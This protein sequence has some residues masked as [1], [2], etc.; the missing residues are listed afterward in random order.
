MA[1]GLRRSNATT[2]STSPGG[3][4]SSRLGTETN[5][6]RFKKLPL[7]PPVQTTNLPQQSSTAAARSQSLEVLQR[8]K[9]LLAA[10]AVSN[11]GGSGKNDI[12]APSSPMTID[13]TTNSSSENVN[14]Q[15]NVPNTIDG[16]RPA[17]PV[18]PLLSIPTKPQPPAPPPP[19]PKLAIS[20]N[21]QK[22][23]PPPPQ[24]PLLQISKPPPSINTSSQQQPQ[25]PPFLQIQVN[26]KSN[27]HHHQ[28]QQSQAKPQQ[29]PFLPPLL[30]ID[31]TSSNSQ[32]PITNISINTN[33]TGGAPGAIDTN[34]GEH[35]N[36]DNNLTPE[37]AKFLTNGSQYTTRNTYTNN[38]S[39]YCGGLSIATQSRDNK[40]SGGNELLPELSSNFSQLKLDIPGISGNHHHHR[41]QD[42]IASQNSKD[43]DDG[44][45]R[46]HHDPNVEIVRDDDA[47]IGGG[48]GGGRSSSRQATAAAA[49]ITG[50][51]SGRGCG[52]EEAVG[53]DGGTT[54]TTV[55]AD[56]YNLIPENI[57]VVERIGEGAVGTVHRVKYLPTSKT[58][59]RKSVAVYPDDKNH[60]QLV[61]ELAFLK[62]CK[63]K[64]IVSFYGAY[65][66]DD[67]NDGPS[68]YMCMEYC[69][70]G[71]LDAIYKRLK[72]MNAQIGERVLGKIAEAVLNGL[73]YLHQS[74]IIHRDVKPSNILVTGKGRVKLCDFGV[75]GELVD[76]IAQTFV[77]TSYYMAPE[78]IQGKGYAV[79]SD[80]WSLGLTLIEIAQN[81]FPFPPAGHPEMTVI[82]LLDYIVNVPIPTL[83]EDS[84]RWSPEC[85][86]F[87][88]LCMIK[89][90]NQRPT[91]KQLLCHEFIKKSEERKLDLKKWIKSVWSD[92]RGTT[93]TT[94]K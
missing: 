58:M 2:S 73:V 92:P 13:A 66:Q 55:A 40:E 61:R 60:R 14:Q 89:D 82:E 34:Q 36:S 15:T 83:N 5:Y 30:K 80:V 72:S 37:V 24:P 81:R 75:S 94:S 7:P 53:G 86:K 9:A 32:Q 54:T 63:S 12:S 49:A 45:Q 67:D 84:G 1:F 8:N 76:S 39:G 50:E 90:P 65:Y 44:R 48:G 69:Q 17:K 91:P 10:T 16:N 62:Q 70:G 6:S 78:R 77:G 42:S 31:T 74:S 68:I 51:T 19:P 43:V 11:S 21:L 26:T 25:P 57:E 22:P 59:A 33:T 29:P 18:V 46:G 52:G 47:N 28:Q 71:S 88:N 85:V 23:A 56:E 79:Q 64:Y 27:S 93:T 4:R 41:R 3:P 20:T 87:V 35:S 38:T